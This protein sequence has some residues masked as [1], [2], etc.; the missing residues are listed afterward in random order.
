[1]K[2][3]RTEFNKSSKY[4][5]LILELYPKPLHELKPTIL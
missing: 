3:L 4:V 1:M 5:R 2:N